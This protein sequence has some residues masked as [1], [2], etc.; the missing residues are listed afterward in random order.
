MQR[1]S[2][3]MFLLSFIALGLLFSTQSCT[4]DIQEIDLDKRPVQRNLSSS[5]I[6]IVNLGEYNQIKAN[7]EKLT[8]FIY[9]DPEGPDAQKFPGT[10][11]FP[12]NGHLGKIW[13]VPK[14]LF[15][16]A[17]KINVEASFIGRSGSNYSFTPIKFLME[18]KGNNPVDYYLLP[19]RIEGPEFAE[20]PR[21]ITQP[22]KP[23]HFKIRIINLMAKFSG[24]STEAEDLTGPITLTYADGTPVSP[25]TSKI[26]FT[27]R[28]SEYVEVPYGTYQFKVLNANDNRQIPGANAKNPDDRL[29]DF[30]TSSI[31]LAFERPSHLH[32]APIKT[33]QP[34]GVYTIV[35]FPSRY[36]YH[37]TAVE[38]LTIGR[39]HGFEVIEDITPALNSSYANLQVVNTIADL[40]TYKFQL[41]NEVLFENI[42]FTKSSPYKSISTGNKVFNLIDNNN[43]VLAKIESQILAGQNY[44]F[45]IH[46]DE[47]GENRMKLVQNDLSNVLFNDHNI[48]EDGKNGY[49]EHDFLIRYRFFNFS[50]GNPDVSFTSNNGQFFRGERAAFSNIQFAEIPNGYPYV[51]GNFNNP[52]HV[53]TFRSQKLVVPGKWAEDIPAL[54]GT[55]LL[56]NPELYK[57]AKRP[58]PY[59]EAGVFSIALVGK[60]S[61]D[62]SKDS[63]NKLMVVKHIK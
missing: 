59:T 40:G 28:V 29:I 24:T 37:N 38:Q 17:E 14:N 9:R 57:K 35:V 10:L 46:K 30:K 11:Y 50:E 48:K 4:K 21:S 5:L 18:Q 62:K 22:S 39:Q 20:I 61:S 32:Y 41:D 34:G 49:V 63:N 12:S 26:S 3:Y 33:Y 58:L 51:Q 52:F 19:G 53:L 54:L 13:N 23:D 15:S 1:I 2:K 56:A 8:N 43:K 44:S 42:G 36:S 47:K 7:E 25:L 60:N 27:D 6:R 55:D 16:K 45:W 31:S